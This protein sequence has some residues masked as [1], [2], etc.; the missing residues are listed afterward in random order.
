MHYLTGPIIS[1]HSL[2]RRTGYS[3]LGVLCCLIAL[4]VVSKFATAE[5]FSGVI[6]AESS[7]PTT[8]ENICV[9]NFSPYENGAFSG[10]NYINFRL[11]QRSRKCWELFDCSTRSKGG[12]R[13]ASIIMRSKGGL[14][15]KF[16]NPDDCGTLQFIGWGL[17]KILDRDRGSQSPV[18]VNRQGLIVYGEHIRPQ[19]PFGGGFRTSYEVIG[20]PPKICCE[21]DQ[22]KSDNR[23][24]A[25]DVNEPPFWRRIP[26]SLFLLFGG[27][28]FQ[29][30]GWGYFYSG[31]KRYGRLIVCSGTVITL[32]GVALWLCSGF[33][34]S[35]GWWI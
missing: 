19:L 4:F 29:D 26:V 25:G 28:Y 32:C 31:R 13:P 7:I 17:P 22:Y 21:T 16:K 23:K 12:I 1:C 15:W 2:K 27:F 20:S 6:Q 24:G 3:R 5:I 35:W 34:W 14:Q 18:L 33:R 9:Q 10:T 11:I 8:L 30:R